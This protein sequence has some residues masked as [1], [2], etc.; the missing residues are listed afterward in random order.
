MAHLTTQESPKNDAAEFVQSC[1]SE[2]ASRALSDRPD[3]EDVRQ[4]SSYIAQ[5]AGYDSTLLEAVPQ[6][7]NLGLGC[8][9]PHSIG[10]LMPGDRILDIGSGGGLDCFIAARDVGASGYVIGVDMSPDMINLARR[11]AAK[12]ELNNIEFRLGKVEQLPVEDESIDVVISNCVINLVRDKER[13]YANIFN[14]LK[15]GGRL[16]ISDTVVVDEFPP[17]L[18]NGFAYRPIRLAEYEA[19]LIDAG[20]ANVSIEPKGLSCF[21]Y[22]TND[23]IVRA[24]RAEIED[25]D[26]LA[27]LFASVYVRG[28]RE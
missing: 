16:A 18:D 11:N 4:R 17:I 19:I 2:T 5:K 1:Y 12:F 22:N 26:K 14:S 24:L 15:K 8:G 7:A 20:F 27:S 23:P 3:R 6:D 10:N 28:N 21:G 13:A 9:N 25:P